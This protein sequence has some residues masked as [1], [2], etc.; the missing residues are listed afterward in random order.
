MRERSSFNKCSGE[1]MEV[2]ALEMK[3]IVRSASEPISA[4]ETVKGQ[5][6]RAW[7]RLR[8]P[9][10]W[11]VKAA[12]YGE[13]G[14]WSGQ[15]IEDMRRRYETRQSKEAKGRAQAT[16]L[17][18]LYAAIADRLAETDAHFHREDIAGLKHAARALG[19]LDSPVARA[20][21]KD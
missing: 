19:A 2:L 15:A 12:W 21:T 13:A 7:E 10:W 4:G 11:R 9:P 8:R 1:L 20:S 16:E 17:G 18:Q 5:M 14:R 3:Q 6:R